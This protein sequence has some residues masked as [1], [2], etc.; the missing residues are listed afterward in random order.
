MSNSKK[1]CNTR[2]RACLAEGDTT[3]EESGGARDPVQRRDGEMSW[4][5]LYFLP[6]FEIP[7][8]PPLAELVVIGAWLMQPAGV[9]PP[10]QN[11][12]AGVKRGIVPGLAQLTCHLTESIHEHLL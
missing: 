12:I 8:V 4:L 5:F 10:I 2:G 6:P 1:P 11:R 3:R 7:Q 9:I